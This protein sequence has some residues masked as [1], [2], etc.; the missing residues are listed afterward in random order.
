M[1]KK[2]KIRRKSPT[3][4]YSGSLIQQNFGESIDKGYLMWDTD[5]FEHKR[6]YIMNDYGFAKIDIARGE[7]AEQRIDFIKFSNNKRKTKVYITWEDYEENYSVEKENQIKRLVKDKY[8]CESVR[9]EFKEIRRDIADI[10]EQEDFEY[11]TFEDMFEEWVNESEADIDK[12]LMKELVE[13]SREVD[14]TLEIDENQLNLIDDWDL[15]KIEISNHPNIL[16]MYNHLL[17]YYLKT[18]LQNLFLLQEHT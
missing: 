7:D 5:T 1:G 8:K 13:F 6:K 3:A 2:I 14:T 10:G 18:V 15:N 12:D 16:L 9:V 11:F 17:N 4:G